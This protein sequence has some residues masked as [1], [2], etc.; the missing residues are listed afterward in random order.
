MEFIKVELKEELANYV[1]IVCN[2]G[3]DYLWDKAKGD[4]GYKPP[5]VSADSYGDVKELTEIS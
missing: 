1:G 5:I 2:R 3:R 4:R